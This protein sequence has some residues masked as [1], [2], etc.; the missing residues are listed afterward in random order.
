M[1]LVFLLLILLF[2][3]LLS[4]IEFN[5]YNLDI[6]EKKIDFKADISL[7][8]FCF[9]RILSIRIN[10]KEIERFNK[11]IPKVKELKKFHINID[12]IRFKAK[13]GL[14][15]MG[16][17]NIVIIIFSSVFPNLI[18]KRIKRKKLKYEIIPDYKNLCFKLERENNNFN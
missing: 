7:K 6:L 4:K 11:K 12:R 15:D 9:L 1:W 8:L 13:I 14:L 3:I 17:T 2:G 5:L 16:L 18:K 10:N